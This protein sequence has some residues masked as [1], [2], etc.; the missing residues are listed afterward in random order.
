M[1]ENLQT[2]VIKMSEDLADSI[3]KMVEK[4]KTES[5]TSYGTLEEINKGL[6]A[7]N[8]TVCVL[9]RIDRI[10]RGKSPAYGLE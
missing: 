4:S 8:S 7:L 10:Q 6:A 3:T 5:E 9:E 2:K 1:L